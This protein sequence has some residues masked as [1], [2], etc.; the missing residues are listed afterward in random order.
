[1]TQLQRSVA[2]D[3]VVFAGLSND[4]VVVLQRNHAVNIFWQRK[5]A[6]LCV[7]IGI[8]ACGT[9]VLRKSDIA[10]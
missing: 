5:D 4:R 7:G 8:I 10:N 9:V 2:F 6:A 1:M 3:A